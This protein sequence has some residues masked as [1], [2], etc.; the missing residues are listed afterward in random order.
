MAIKTDAELTAQVAAA[1]VV[2][3]TG[4]I[5]PPV[6]KAIEDNLI[7]SKLN[8]KDGGLVVQALT[9]YT[10]E[11][12]ITDNKHFTHK[13]YV[14]D[15]IASGVS[16]YLPLSAGA[17]FPLTGDLF[18]DAVGIDMVA[19]GGSDVLNLGVTN[20]NV[21]NVGSTATTAISLTTVGDYGVF[22]SPTGIDIGADQNIG[23]VSDSG[24]ISLSATQ[25]LLLTYGGAFSFA[26]PDGFTR[27]ILGTLT[28]NHDYT[29]PD[30]TLTFVGEDTAQTLTNKTLT[31]PVINLGSDAD[32]DMYYRLSGNL[33]RLTKG[34]APDGYVITLVAGVPAWAASAGGVPAAITVA[35]E[36]A[37]TTCF[38]AFFTAAT[39]DLGPK[40]NANLTFNSNTGIM[41]LLSPNVTTSLTTPSTSFDLINTTATTVNF[42][43]GASTALNMGHAS[44]TNAFLGATT[45][46]Q[47]VTFTA[48]TTELTELDLLDT[49]YKAALTVAAANSLRIG[50]GFTSLRIPT[51]ILSS[52]GGSTAMT[53]TCSSF[54]VGASGGLNASN[55]FAGAGT[56]TLVHFDVTGS[57]TKVN[58]N[59]EY[60]GY[61]SSA[62]INQT[63][64][65]V[66]DVS[67]FYVNPTITAF[68]S[69]NI[70]SAYRSQI[71]SGT[72]RYGLYMGGTATNY[73]A[74]AIQMADVDIILGT[75][76]GT[77]IGTATSQ[78]LSVWNATPII[79]P[80]S[81]NQAALTNS[82]GGTYDGTLAAISGTG[83]D[84]GINNNFTDIYT[85]LNAMRTAMVDFGSMKGAA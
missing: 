71:A 83:D 22:I 62:T 8:I 47:K 57:F 3:G 52:N 64:T 5:T 46:S 35:D 1:L 65:S 66:G 21:V 23:I 72:N 49:T 40:T 77:K 63:G 27:N 13:K 15:A 24:D 4:C 42:A 43:G 80:A 2:C 20:A 70:L 19:T 16:G 69:T 41:G 56:G 7:S 58:V 18:L 17:S 39:G 74:G 81:A 10:T 82:T 9:G 48:A 59:A 67:F 28:G 76:T 68:V 60:R 31:S 50:S 38:P 54:N 55:G 61:Q 25:D 29:L 84:A 78:K 32:Y 73:F 26:G 12:T 75:T 51:S 37:D 44:G 30:A 6:H 79:Q 36:A 34:A 45:F 33:T 14:D 11:L 85:L 53:W